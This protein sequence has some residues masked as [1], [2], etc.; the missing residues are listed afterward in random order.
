[1]PNSRTEHNLGIA[2]LDNRYLHIDGSKPLTANWDAGGYQV[3]ASEFLVDTTGGIKDA[4]GITFL[5]KHATT[6]YWIGDLLEND[7]PLTLK[8]MSGTAIIELTDSEIY[9]TATVHDFI[10]GSVRI[11]SDNKYLYFGA[12]SDATITYNGTNMLINP[13]LVGTG[14]LNIQGQTLLNDK[15]MFTQVDGNEYIN[16][17]ND[18]YMDYYATTLHRFNQAIDINGNCEANTYSATGVAGIDQVV[19]IIDSKDATHT[20]TFTK[21]LLT[22]YTTA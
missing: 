2:S 18:G 22:A 13:K 1:M 15:L 20:L 10:G 6:G 8:G 14:Y 12:G 3:R 9:Y 16:S 5:Y 4:E 17:L 21:G 19:E 7:L 11:V